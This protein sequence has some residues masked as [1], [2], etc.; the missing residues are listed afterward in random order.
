MLDVHAS[1]CLVLHIRACVQSA[2]ILAYM[3]LC[4]CCAVVHCNAARMCWQILLVHCSFN[5]ASLYVLYAVTRNK[6]EAFGPSSAEAES[7]PPNAFRDV[8]IDQPDENATD[9]DIVP[10]PDPRDALPP[11]QE[12]DKKHVTVIHVY[13]VIYHICVVIC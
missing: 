7:A 9:I 12:Y 10:S 6:S 1:R 11:G 3:L 8:I 2:Y 5:K 13:H 4:A